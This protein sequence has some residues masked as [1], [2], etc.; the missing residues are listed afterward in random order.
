[1]AR[2]ASA[3]VSR[4]SL[5]SRPRIPLHQLAG[6]G[7]VLLF[8]P[9]VALLVANTGLLITGAIVGGIVLL[10]VVLLSAEATFYVLI[11]SMLLS[12]E[13]IVGGLEV[14]GTAATRGVTLRFDDFVI[15]MIGLAWLVRLAVYK[16]AGVLR[17]TRM[18]APILSYIG[19]CLLSTATGILT[20]EVAGLTGLFFV[21]KYFEYVVIYFLVVN[22]VHDRAQVK[23]LVFATL[24]T[25]FL[26][27]V[28]VSMQIPAGERITAPFEGEEGE[29]NTLGGYLVL[30]IGMALALLSEA[31]SGD[32]RGLWGGLAAIMAIPLVYTYSRTSWLAFVAMV[33]TTVLL[34]RRKTMFLIVALAG[35]IFLVVSPPEA[36]LE[37]TTYTITG[38]PAATGAITI[39][40]ITIEP[41]AA[42]RLQSWFIA[43]QAVP[44]QPFLGWGVTGFSFID[45]QYPRTLI[46]TGLFGFAM[47]CW[48]LYTLYTL[49]RDLL[50][51]A[52]ERFDTA[53]AIGFLSG[54]AA[55]IVHGIGAN[56]FIIVRIME[57]FWLIAGLCAALLYIN[58]NE[59]AAVDADA[60]IRAAAHGTD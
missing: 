10:L 31:E 55:V 45:S 26:I 56:T 35:L 32:K 38:R 53:L 21:A 22:Y 7:A 42:A 23:R 9:L 49:G 28:I 25:A 51:S 3:T 41:S 14:G 5:S 43:A 18:S 37:R 12:P 15:V 33:A 39:G 52:R 34:C 27:S 4:P 20:G 40:A 48:V 19:V 6:L 16:E 44:Q 47:L 50:L 2:Q 54:L 1:M 11:F 46:E 29:P 57:P 59:T 36:I 8:A 60:A 17:R 30:M 13:F 24:F 58:E